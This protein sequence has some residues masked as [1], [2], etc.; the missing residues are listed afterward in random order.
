MKKIIFVLS[1]VVLLA[2]LTSCTVSD[3]ENS[4]FPLTYEEMVEDYNYFI[5]VAEPFDDRVLLE[6]TWETLIEPVDYQ[7][8]LGGEE[9]DPVNWEYVEEKELWS[10]SNYINKDSLEIDDNSLHFEVSFNGNSYQ[11]VLTLTPELTC[12]SLV[13]FLFEED[14]EICWDAAYEPQLYNLNLYHHWFGS[15]GWG[16]NQYDYQLSGDV[17]SYTLKHSLYLVEEAN[18][19]EAL[20]A[21]IK[22]I[23]YYSKNDFLIYSYTEKEITYDNMLG[24]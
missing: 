2:L 8:V 21:H 20:D 24:K 15:L 5:S 16:S 13:E 3:K 12:E 22:A 7:L 14:L 17:A 1:G 23:N 19:Y 10:S 4:G 6:V 18:G 9:I 11:G